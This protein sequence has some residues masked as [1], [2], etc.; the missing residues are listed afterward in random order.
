MEMSLESLLTEDIEALINIYSDEDILL[1]DLKAEGKGGFTC[2]LKLL[3][4]TGFNEAKIGLYIKC[5]F[6]FGK[7]VLYFYLILRI[8]LSNFDYFFIAPIYTTLLCVWAG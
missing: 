2:T 3:P 7:D 6:I 4:N 5:K 8:F 1:E